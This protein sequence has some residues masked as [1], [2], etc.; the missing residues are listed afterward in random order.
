MYICMCK[1]YVCI[2]TYAYVYVYIRI[3]TTPSLHPPQQQ[4]TTRQ[5]MLP[6]A[7]TLNVAYSPYMAPTSS[8]CKVVKF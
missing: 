1:K 2:S 6:R 4:G 8:E 7:Y 5:E 3:Y